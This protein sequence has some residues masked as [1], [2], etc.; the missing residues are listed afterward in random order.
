MPAAPGAGRRRPIVR[1]R[2]PMQRLGDLIP[3][4]A[5][6][7]GLE[8]ELRLARAISTW[9]AI[10]A[11][12]VPAA[13]GATTAAAHGRLHARR[14]GGRADRRPGAAA[15]GARADHGIPGRAGRAG[16]DASSADRAMPAPVSH[17]HRRARA[18]AALMP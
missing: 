3:E 14:R 9:D 1:R 13:A 7:L 15:P 8:E 18:G 5:R 6:R 10:V 12:H 2:R 17:R 11:E 4:A 16:G